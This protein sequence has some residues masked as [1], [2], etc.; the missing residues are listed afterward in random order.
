MKEEQRFEELKQLNK[1]HVVLLGEK[2]IL[3][4]APH[5]VEQIRNGKI[6]YAEPETALIALHLNSKGYPCV[7]KTRNDNDDANFD[8]KSDYRDNL[9]KYC[10]ENNIK[11]VLDLHQLSDKR[12]MDF[13][14]GTGG[15][16]HKNLLENLK[17]IDIF[18]YYF[19]KNNFS[20]KINDPYDADA[21]NVVSTVC[22]KNSIPSV[23][24]E[25]NCKVVSAF[26]GGTKL[27]AIMKIIEEILL[28]I[29]K[30]QC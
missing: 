18:K 12:E 7:I 19:E 22:A 25:I 16:K 13:C 29:E 3:V 1:N 6:K 15:N 23:L 27:E 9:I 14:L 28:S 5:A 21:P 4:S 10:K 2:N 26:C 30:E 17:I 20:I 8:E 11:F 24:L